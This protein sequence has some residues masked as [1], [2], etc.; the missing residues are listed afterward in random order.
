MEIMVMARLTLPKGTSISKSNRL[1]MA[2]IAIG[3]T[4][5]YI[6]TAYLICLRG[7]ENIS[8]MLIVCANRTITE[9][10]EKSKSIPEKFIARLDFKV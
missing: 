3:R 10:K 7:V 5:R 4:R 8:S 6:F 1:T 2:P 9:T